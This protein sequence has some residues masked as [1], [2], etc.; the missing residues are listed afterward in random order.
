MAWSDAARAAAA[1]ARRRNRD[2]LGQPSPPVSAALQ[3]V[4][5]R[6]RKASE[7]RITKDAARFR[8]KHGSDQAHIVKKSYAPKFVGLQSYGP[9]WKAPK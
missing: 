5:D 8:A 9:N 3:R 1:E 7:L 4:F 2:P 6:N